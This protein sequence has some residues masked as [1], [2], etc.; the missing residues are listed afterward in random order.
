MPAT[1]EDFE[2]DYYI[3]NK[4]G[5]GGNFG[6]LYTKLSIIIVYYLKLTTLIK[7]VFIFLGVLIKSN[8]VVILK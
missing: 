2:R 7:T 5:I 3:Q 8:R 6:K 4:L 1:I